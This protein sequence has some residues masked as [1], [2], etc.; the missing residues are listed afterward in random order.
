[1]NTP[2]A[3]LFSTIPFPRRRPL[4]CLD[5]YYD[6]HEDH[7]IRVDDARRYRTLVYLAETVPYRKTVITGSTSPRVLLAY[8]KK[9]IFD[10]MIFTPHEHTTV[11]HLSHA[12]NLKKTPVRLYTE[13][14]QGWG[15][16][17]IQI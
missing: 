11:E 3:L 2:R 17:R 10:Y 8:I 7:T 16:D 9:I 12:S 5:G 13:T 1:M 6:V 14:V 15:L 4:E